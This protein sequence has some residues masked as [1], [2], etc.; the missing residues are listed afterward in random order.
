MIYLVCIEIT[1]QESKPLVAMETIAFSIPNLVKVL[2]E[3]EDNGRARRRE[4]LRLGC[5]WLI[6]I[7]NNNTN[8]TLL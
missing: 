7:K 5:I 1:A 6:I 2:R 3:A 8:I 4:K